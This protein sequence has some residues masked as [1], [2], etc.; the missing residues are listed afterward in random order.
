MR[1]VISSVGSILPE[2]FRRSLLGSE[3]V[4]SSIANVMHAVLNKLPGKR[5][6]CLPCRGV[7]SGYRMKIDWNRHRSFIYGTWET[8]VV[9]ALV[10]VVHSGNCVVDVG[11][12]IGFYTLL[13]SKLV[14]P[15]GRVLAFEP[16]MWNFSVLY[17]NI[18]L[19]NCSHVTAINKAV[20]D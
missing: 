3:S 17:D 13:L 5:V 20:L 14:G 11:A 18:R 9:D 6:T 12:H 7:L 16:L 1:R 2:V 19:N 10:D 4:P 15:S 8:A